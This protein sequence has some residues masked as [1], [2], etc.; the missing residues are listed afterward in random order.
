MRARKGWKYSP[1]LSLTSGLMAAGGQS[2]AHAPDQFSQG[3]ESRV[4]IAQEAG[5]ALG[6]L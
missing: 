6:S 2:H 4:R 1:T 5:W 3:K